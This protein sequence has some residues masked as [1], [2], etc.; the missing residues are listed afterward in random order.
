EEPG[1][2]A[3]NLGDLQSGRNYV[4]DFVLGELHI[5]AGGIVQ[6]LGERGGSYQDAVVVAVQPATQIGSGGAQWDSSLQL[7][8]PDA[9]AAASEGS[10]EPATGLAF[11]MSQ[12]SDGVSAVQGL[13]SIVNGGLRLP[14]GFDE[15]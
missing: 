14:E 7:T 8:A 6:R 13:Y 15:P 2:Y 10:G 12:A 3:I 1:I 11:G 9:V 5:N 4:I